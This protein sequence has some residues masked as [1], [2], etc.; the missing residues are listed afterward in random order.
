MYVT[1]IIG[2]LYAVYIILVVSIMALFVYDLVSGKRAKPI[3]NISL[4]VWIV[5][6]II[7]AVVFHLTTYF[8]LP[9]VKWEF[10]GKN[11]IPAKEVVI[12]IKDYQFLLP[13]DPITLEADKPIKFSVTSQDV[14]Y[15]FGV[16]REDGT[17]VFQI[18]VVPAHVNEI[19][20]I[21]HEIGKYT[22]R[23]TE[24]SGPENWKMVLKDIILVESPR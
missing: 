17:L 2:I 21:F 3:I 15:G 11:L 9:W 10:M 4:E 6:L 24:Y 12:D 19:T 23:S 18:Q 20:W 22:V 7:M 1:T 14:T 16:F 8:K 13:E 5:F